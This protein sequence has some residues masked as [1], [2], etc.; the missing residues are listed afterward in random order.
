MT[1]ARPSATIFF[2][3]ASESPRGSA[4]RAFNCLQLIELREVGRRRDEEREVGPALARLAELDE[5]H[6]VRALGERPGS[7]RA[8]CPSWRACDR[9]PSGSRRT[10]PATAAPAVAP[11]PRRYG[12]RRPIPAAEARRGP[13]QVERDGGVSSDTPSRQGA[14][15]EAARTVG[16]DVI[17][18]GN[19]P[20]AWSSNAA[21]AGTRNGSS[22][23]AL[24]G[25]ELVFRCQPDAKR[26]SAKI[27]RIPT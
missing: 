14:F 21:G 2:A 6:L 16:S 4:R 23:V 27:V 8:A 7:T 1:T 22:G 3:S 12:Y 25:D 10:A 13:E 26:A 19:R 20:P 24:V 11:G 9:R 5:P 18:D 15:S 17:I